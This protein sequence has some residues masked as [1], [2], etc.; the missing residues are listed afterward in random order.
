[1]F[2][3]TQQVPQWEVLRTEPSIPTGSKRSH[4]FSGVEDFFSDMKKRRV[5]PSY[6]PRKSV[7]ARPH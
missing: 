7:L 3:P 1:M 6:D 5:N 2:L 4:D